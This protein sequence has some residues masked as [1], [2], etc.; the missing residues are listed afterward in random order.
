[1]QNFG[2]YDLRLVN[3]GPFVLERGDG[4]ERASTS[5][6]ENDEANVAPDG[7]NAR[8]GIN[9]GAALGPDGL[10]HGDE[11]PPALRPTLKSRAAESDEEDASSKTND[12]GTSSDDDD[13]RARRSARRRTASRALRTGFW[14]TRPGTTRTS[15]PSKIA[16]SSW[17]PRRGL[18]ETFRWSPRGSPRRCSWRSR[19]EAKSRCCSG[20]N[21][22]A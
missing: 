9:S 10:G 3:P 15:T 8:G 17:R 20:T 22:R 4:V 6:D 12:D 7:A 1:M 2:V 13:I 19:N 11:L 18:G 16:R 14:R 21:A 5:D